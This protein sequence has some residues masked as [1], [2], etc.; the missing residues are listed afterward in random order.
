MGRISS[1][2][3]FPEDRRLHSHRENG[4]RFPESHNYHRRSPSRSRSPSYSS[5]PPNDVYNRYRR[6]SPDYSSYPRRSPR[7]DE[8]LQSDGRNRNRYDDGK[9]PF[10]DRGYKNIRHGESESDEELK[11]LGFEEYR[12]LK[13]QKLRKLLRNCIWNSTPSPPRDPNQS[14]D[15]EPE[16]E[17]TRKVEEDK[18]NREDN[19][20]KSGS[21]KLSRDSSESESE[22]E[23]EDFESRS[24]DSLSWKKRKSRKS[25]FRSRARRSKSVS[26]S[27]SGSEESSDDGSEEE[28]RRRR[29]RKSKKENST[30]S[31]RSGRSRRRKSNNRRSY[32]SE[33]QTDE[34]ETEDSNASDHGKLKKGNRFPSLMSRRSKKKKESDKESSNADE[35]SS[36]SEIDGKSAKQKVDEAKVSDENVAE[37][38]KFKEMIESRNKLT[39]DNEPVVGPMPLPRAEGHISYGGALRPGEGDAIAQYVQ[40]GK[41][42][43]R[44]GEVGLSAEEIQNFETLGY[45]MSGSRHQRMNAIRI[46]KEN[47]V[48]GAE[49][50]RALAMFNYE[51]KS[52]REQ[53]VMADL[54]RLVQRH[55]GQDSGPSHDPFAGRAGEGGDV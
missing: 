34:S 41:R 32:S 40:Q 42:I 10:L 1:A 18:E 22:S 11:C 24:D 7:P 43:P 20:L 44:R 49:D 6:S 3:E 8:T 52:K 17:I 26:E 19:K 13:R 33:S 4:R 55:I 31:K 2:V 15:L 36:D 12:R 39:L 53:K 21:K 23:P 28:N 46:R 35:S 45:V 9:K 50:K 14:S 37:L 51:E 38:L 27:K 48:Y 47:Q 54:Q 5:S 16:D 29:R 30:R 25:S